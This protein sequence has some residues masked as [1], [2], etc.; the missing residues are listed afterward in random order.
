M[1][2]TVHR[3]SVESAST[4]KSFMFALSMQSTVQEDCFCR[5]CSDD[6]CDRC[7]AEVREDIAMY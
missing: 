3:P 1:L 2:L 6:Y 7:E 5:R 4:I